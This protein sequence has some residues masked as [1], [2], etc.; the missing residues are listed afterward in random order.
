MLLD[1][2]TIYLLSFRMIE[3]IGFLLPAFPEDL[4]T[5]ILILFIYFVAHTF[6]LPTKYM[7]MKHEILDAFNPTKQTIDQENIP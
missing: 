1:Q 5:R 4:Y 2:P 3:C 6:G 7:K